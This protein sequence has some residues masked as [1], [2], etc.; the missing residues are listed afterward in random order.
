MWERMADG[1]R[2]APAASCALD[3]P[4]HRDRLRGP[5]ARSRSRRAARSARGRRGDLLA[6]AAHGRRDRRAERPAAGARGR[7]RAALPRL[8]L[9]RPRARRTTS[10][11]PTTGSTSTTRTSASG[12]SRTSAPGAPTWSR[13]PSAPASGSSTSASRATS[14]GT[15]RDAELVAARIRGA[16]D[17]SGS[18]SARGRVTGHVV[19]VPKAYPI[20]DAELR[21]T[22]SRRCAAGSMGSTGWSRSAATGCTA[23]TT[24]TTRC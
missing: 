4:G 8:R 17:D 22:G 18:A 16:R 7:R 5:A 15:R 6:A 12:G 2:S 21:A 1:D 11:S 23:T 24:P 9:R 3:S 10:P 13:S 14:S 19:R 20:Y